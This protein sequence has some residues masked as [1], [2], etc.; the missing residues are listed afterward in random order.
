MTDQEKLAVL[1]AAI[2]VALAVP[3][4]NKVRAELMR[5]LLD[6]E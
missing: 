3:L 6:T 2:R 5:A 1:A 4:P